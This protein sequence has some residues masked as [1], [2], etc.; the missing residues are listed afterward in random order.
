MVI[1]SPLSLAL[2][3]ARYSFERITKRPSAIRSWLAITSTSSR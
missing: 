1:A 2:T 3:A